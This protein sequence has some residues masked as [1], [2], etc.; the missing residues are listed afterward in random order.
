[1][2]L[3]TRQIG[4]RRIG[5]TLDVRFAQAFFV[6]PNSEN[7]PSCDVVYCLQVP[8]PPEGHYA[9][10]F[11]TLALDLEPPEETIFGRIK[12]EVRRQIRQLEKEGTHTADITADPS[13]AMVDAFCAFY[14]DFAGSKGVDNLHPEEMR[15]IAHE[16]A[17]V[18]AC[19]RDR[20]GTPLVW[21]AYYRGASRAVQLCSA[22]HFRST[23]DR[24]AR[25]V[26]GKANRWLHW[27]TLLHFRGMGIAL[28]DFG[29]W[30]AGTRDQD[31]L[32]INAFKEEFG[33]RLLHEWN[34]RLGRSMKGKA[35]VAMKRWREHLQKD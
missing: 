11:C 6:P 5:W 9:W 30:Y 26:I 28:F 21:H 34:S 20:D 35:L 17:L 1:M 4:I 33:G 18:L 29:G 25:A 14:A 2:I 32:R 13:P 7:L 3:Y 22:S 16:R 12:P 10:P 8:E 27:R 31:L 24:S 23:S 15:A 19:A